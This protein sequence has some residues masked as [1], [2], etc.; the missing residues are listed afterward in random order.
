M[1][2]KDN[3]FHKGVNKNNYKIPYKNKD[4]LMEIIVSQ[5]ETKLKL[6]ILNWGGSRVVLKT[7]IISIVYEMTQ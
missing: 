1:E 3:V 4:T 6:F 5:V 2:I 7:T